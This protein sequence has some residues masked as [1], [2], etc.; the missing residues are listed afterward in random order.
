MM[1]RK[2]D[3]LEKDLKEMG[4]PRSGG[5]AF[6]TFFDVAHA[7]AVNKAFLET[8]LAYRYLAFNCSFCLNLFHQGGSL[9]RNWILSS[10]NNDFSAFGR[11]LRVQYPAPEPGDVIWHHLSYRRHTTYPASISSWFE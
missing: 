7:E 4:H 1:Q 3:D 2:I 10:F 11:F 8:G 5:M 6:V 9:M